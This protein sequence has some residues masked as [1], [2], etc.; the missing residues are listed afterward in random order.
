MLTALKSGNLALRFGL[1]LCLL[2]AFAYW[3]FRLGRG[4][5]LKLLLGLGTP[6]MAAVVWA[7]FVAPKATYPVSEVARLV[8]ELILFGL[9]ATALNVTGKP[10]LA[11]ALAA[12]YVINRVLLSVWGQ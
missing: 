8:I 9:A 10:S 3:G 12:I 6:A 5:P 2:A 7:L 4:L 1:E 11:W